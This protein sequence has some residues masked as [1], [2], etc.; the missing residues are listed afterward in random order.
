[1]FVFIDVARENRP[2]IF[3]QCFVFYN[4]TVQYYMIYMNN[5]TPYVLKQH[6]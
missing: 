5:I 2:I 1:M 3:G 4:L 6:T